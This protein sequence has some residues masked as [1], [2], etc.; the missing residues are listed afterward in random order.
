MVAYFNHQDWIRDGKKAEVDWRCS[1]EGLGTASRVDRRTFLRGTSMC[2]GAAER[3]MCLD[4]IAIQ[5]KR[6]QRMNNKP[7]K[8]GRDSYGGKTAYPGGQTSY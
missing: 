8:D 3:L 4:I 2:L 5:L 1:L 7:R 6:S